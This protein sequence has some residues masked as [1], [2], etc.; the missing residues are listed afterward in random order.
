VES[1]MLF[2][3]SFPAE[4]HIT[5]TAWIGPFSRVRSYVYGQVSLADEGPVAFRAYI[6]ASDTIRNH[7]ALQAARNRKFCMTTIAFKRVFSGMIPHMP[8]EQT[9]VQKAFLTYRRDIW[10]LL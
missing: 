9:L 6:G 7:V 1:H 10:P 8:G 5:F 4:T 3:V 2:Q